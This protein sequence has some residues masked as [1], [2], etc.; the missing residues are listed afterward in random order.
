MGVCIEMFLQRPR[1]ALRFFFFFFLRQ[2]GNAATGFHEDQVNSVPEAVT[3]T[4][5]PYSLE[6]SC[7]HLRGKLVIAA[8]AV[9]APGLWAP[10]AKRLSQAHRPNPTPTMQRK[11][12]AFDQPY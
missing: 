1:S 9:G 2:D 6:F 8:V 10:A 11:Q 4:N 7:G 3:L 12:G 5:D